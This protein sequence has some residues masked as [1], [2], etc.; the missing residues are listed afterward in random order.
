M[1]L[2]DWQ[3]RLSVHFAALRDSRL[4][5]GMSRPVF[6]LEHNLG[7][8][9]LTDLTALLREHTRWTG[10]ANQHWLVWV[11]YAA[12]VGYKFAGDQYWQTFAESLPDWHQHADGDYIKHA[13][14]DFGRKFN[15]A[16]PSGRFASHFTTICWPITHAILPKDLQRHLASVLYDI[17]QAFTPSLMASPTALGTLLDA[18]SGR[19]NSRFR[20][21]SGQ[22]DLLG[23]I[24]SALLLSESA[25]SSGLIL[26]SSLKRIT[27]D[28]QVEQKSRDWLKGAKQRA[29]TVSITGA[30]PGSPTIFERRPTMDDPL[31]Q[32]FELHG[33]ADVESNQFKLFVRQDDTRRWSIRA[34]LP[35]FGILT[36]N[37]P[38]FRQAFA[39]Q[40]SYIAGATAPFFPEK[41][42]LYGRQDIEFANIPDSNAPLLTLESD[43]PGLAEFLSRT[44]SFPM[45]I[46]LLFRLNGDG[47]STY[48]TSGVIRPGHKYLYLTRS[49]ERELP[50]LQG[51]SS[52]DI[53]CKGMRGLLITVP[54]KPSSIYRETAR[55]MGLLVASGLS[56]HPVGYPAIFWDGD[57]C[58]VWSETGPQT[59]RVTA[60]FEV[61]Q[62]TFTLQGASISD[63]KTVSCPNTKDIL[64][65]LE[66]SEV[67]DYNLHITATSK[68]FERPLSAGLM[69]KIIALSDTVLERK[70]PQGFAVLA[71]P[72]APTLEELWNDDAQIDIYGPPGE[73]LSFQ[74]TFFEDP[75]RKISNLIWRGPP[76]NLPVEASSWRRYLADLKAKPAVQTAFDDSISCTLCFRSLRL[77]Q[78]EL[79]CDREFVPFRWVRKQ[80]NSGFKLR[81]VQNDS[82]E[83]LTVGHYEFASPAQF[84]VISS[85]P[86]EGFSVG[87][88]GG[89]FVATRGSSV[90][91]VIVPTSQM[92][93]GDLGAKVSRIPAAKTPEALMDL[94]ATSRS[95]A[96]AQEVG[97]VISGGKRNAALLGL[98]IC[99]VE[100]L[101]GGTW[102]S[103][104]DAVEFG[105]KPLSALSEL[106]RSHLCPTLARSAFDSRDQFE[107]ATPTKLTDILHDLLAQCSCEPL[108]LSPNRELAAKTAIS[109]LIPL[110]AYGESAFACPLNLSVADATFWLENPTLARLVRFSSFARVT[111][112]LNT[113]GVL[114][115]EAR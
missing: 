75:E 109:S 7:D 3:E 65:D 96:L 20:Q 25:D 84:Q 69:V 95:W 59:L 26:A 92:G 40:R 36:R 89:L 38:V 82:E 49:S 27:S 52:V 57:G 15:G 64:I 47:S 10:P 21:L 2:K 73:T 58:G 93:F 103:I 106:L 98:R 88:S 1:T 5:S 100:T 63:V 91:S 41:F 17:R 19:T 112:A 31:P 79:D 33:L 12:E 51:S 46:S 68:Q 13:F 54:D 108:P 77:G 76:L 94:M 107:V 66:V 14:E 32:V 45:L 99:L 62:F 101:C 60:D 83:P 110:L 23:Q 56:I 4:A 67:G 71:S 104:E 42:L 61:T 105:R 55:S 35:N 115:L 74:L 81:L 50:G 39:N 70:Q 78:F 44:C 85:I 53:S 113:S 30:R 29:A 11:V 22:H 87:K 37:Y 72:Q 8:E 80:K 6:A 34:T 16:Q 18:H 28:L 9:E 24:A 90:A 97:D 43:V 111:K 48:L 114:A 102:M 86:D